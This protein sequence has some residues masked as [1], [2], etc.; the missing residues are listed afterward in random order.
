MEQTVYTAGYVWLHMLSASVVK[1]SPE[2]S[3]NIYWP[4][5]VGFSV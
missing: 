5:Q 2:S 1:D 4:V 3:V